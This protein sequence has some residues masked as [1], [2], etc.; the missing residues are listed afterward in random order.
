M[1][2]DVQHISL[3]QRWTGLAPVIKL[4]IAND[5]NSYMELLTRQLGIDDLVH[6]WTHRYPPFLLMAL[7]SAGQDRRL[8]L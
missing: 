3:V 2:D 7:S 1:N 5:R 8:A 6:Y 4:G